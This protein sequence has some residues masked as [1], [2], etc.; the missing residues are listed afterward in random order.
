M[1]TIQRVWIGTNNE[2][3]WQY[4]EYERLPLY[5]TNCHLQGHNIAVCKR[6][7]K[8]T[9]SDSCA[10]LVSQKQDED[11]TEIA[12]DTRGQQFK[13]KWVAINTYECTSS[14]PIIFL[15]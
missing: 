4:V 6:I 1:P 11:N 7:S 2:E 3:F 8:A 9:K 13:K 12:K 5:C 15:I 10:L 14:E